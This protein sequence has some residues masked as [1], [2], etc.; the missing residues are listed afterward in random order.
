MIKL[1]RAHNSAILFWIGVPVSKSLFLVWNYFKV[2]HRWERTFLI[3]WASSRIMN[4]H[5]SLLKALS[6]VTVSWYEVITTWNGESAFSVNFFSEKNFLIVFLCFKLPQYGSTLSEGQNF[7]NS[8][9]QLKRVLLGATTRNGPQIFLL[10]EICDRS[11]IAWIVFPR[12]ISSA[13]IPLIPCSNKLFNHLKPL[14]WYS[15]SVPIKIAGGPFSY[16]DRAFCYT[17]EKLSLLLF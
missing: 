17:S 5:F 7:L 14:I 1:S 10:K 8:C 9:Y 13:K 11:A 3:A 4:C 6:S 12:P 15:F 16:F 2:F